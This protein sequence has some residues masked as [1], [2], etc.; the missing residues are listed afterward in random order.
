M[1]EE[2]EEE[3]EGEILEGAEP[4]YPTNGQA[5]E[6][7][8]MHNPNIYHDLMTGVMEPPPQYGYPTTKPQSMAEHLDRTIHENDDLK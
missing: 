3:Q 4:N 2:E 5:P 7:V 8:E 1:N 6:Y